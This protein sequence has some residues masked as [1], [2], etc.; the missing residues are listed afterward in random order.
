ML[1]ILSGKYKGTKLDSISLN[2]LRPTQAIVKKSI[3]DSIMFFDNKVVL[4]LYC[5][6]GT[7]GL[8]A[9]SRGAKK[10]KFVD[11]NYKVLTCLSKNVN[12]LKLDAQCELVKSDVGKYIDSDLKQYDIIFAD[13]PYK[14]DCF[15]EVFPFVKKS[16]NKNGIFVYESKKKDFNLDEDIKVKYFGSTQILIWKQTI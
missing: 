4:D 11:N 8:E 15:F 6:I 14:K 2:S 5:G 3:M 9:L 16:L 1:K 13:P 7:L 12:K 10:V